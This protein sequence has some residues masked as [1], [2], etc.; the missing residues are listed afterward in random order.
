MLVT[1]SFMAYIQYHVKHL[2]DYNISEAKFTVRNT[3]ATL[4][5]SD[6]QQI[7]IKNNCIGLHL[8]MYLDLDLDS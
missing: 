2:P 7:N 5:H 6:C 4:L 8:G 3:I 1:Y